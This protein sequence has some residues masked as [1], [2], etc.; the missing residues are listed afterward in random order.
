VKISDPTKFNVIDEH[1]IRVV[2]RDKHFYEHRLKENKNK[3]SENDDGTPTYKIVKI[4]FVS[5][6]LEDNNILTS[7]E[8][9]CDPTRP[10]GLIQA[11]G[12]P[13][14]NTWSGFYAERLRPVPLC[15][16][17]EAMACIEDV[18]LKVTADRPFTTYM[19]DYFANIIQHPESK[20][21]VGILLQGPMGCG[22]ST[23]F[24]L[25][26]AIVGKESSSVTG[27]P[28]EDYFSR[29]S[30]GLKNVVIA[31]IDEA[32]D[33]WDKNQIIKDL[34]TA[35]TRT[36]EDKGVKPY[37][38]DNHV[39]LVCTTNDNTP[40][41]FEK[42]DR[43]WAATKCPNGE[44]VRSSAY[45]IPK[46]KYLFKKDTLR[47]LYQGF[48]KRDITH[49]TCWSECRPKTSYYEQCIRACAPLHTRFLSYVAQRI[50]SN[51][52]VGGIK[53][54]GGVGGI[55]VVASS[56]MFE[57]FNCWTKAANYQHRSNL[58]SFSELMMEYTNHENSGLS[59]FR[60]NR[61]REYRVDATLL[62]A[63]LKQRGEFDEHAAN[64]PTLVVDF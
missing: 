3:Q 16:E 11:E 36:F 19:M 38:M 6:W 13:T 61:Q 35:D 32:S 25:W 51:G 50:Q 44:H 10:W 62:E 21:Q 26:R 2:H 63:C 40:I 60:T 12:V 59:W 28:N 1:A 48:K 53:S 4:L 58:N 20:T 37:T 8:L 46:R 33:L 22:K 42:G 57:V 54:N 23:I 34:I 5:R 18:I 45:W 52:G 49:I 17:I 39:N 43:R 14:Y 55:V 41:K 24:N 9:C 31:Q 27:K 47:A 15:M 29:F 7:R 56:R 30:T 64:I